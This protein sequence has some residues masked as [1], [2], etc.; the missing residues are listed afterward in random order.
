MNPSFRP[1]GT[2][3][4]AFDSRME[5]LSFSVPLALPHSSVQHCFFRVI[6]KR[7][8]GIRDGAKLG[9]SERADFTY[10]KEGAMDFAK[11]HHLARNK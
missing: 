6:W 4:T 8:G 1:Q 10:G 5:P 9:T 2:F 11:A 7:R 3:E